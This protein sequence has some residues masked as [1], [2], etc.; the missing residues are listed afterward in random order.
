MTTEEIKAIRLRFRTASL[1]WLVVIVAAFFLGRQSDEIAARFAHLWQSKTPSPATYRL[2][3]KT[4]GSL[5]FVSLHKV[6]GVVYYGPRIC[7]VNGLGTKTISVTSQ[8]DGNTRYTFWQYDVTTGSTSLVSLDLSVKNSRVTA[9]ENPSP[10]KSAP[11]PTAQ[12]HPPD[13][14]LLSFYSKIPLLSAPLR[15]R[16]KHS[17]HGSHAETQRR[18]DESRHTKLGHR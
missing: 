5:D 7:Q 9:T 16:V 3:Q 11:Q 8:E 14:V 1:L 15:L 4:D 2:V 10:K 6:T 17:I 13:A 12:I 18:R